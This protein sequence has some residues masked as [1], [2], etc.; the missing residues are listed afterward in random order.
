MV[1]SILMKKGLVVLMA[2]V[3]AILWV[4]PFLFL[5][6]SRGRHQ[7]WPPPPHTIPAMK[8]PIMLPVISILATKGLDG[9]CHNSNKGHYVGAFVSISKFKQGPAPKLACPPYHPSDEGS[10]HGDSCFHPCDK[11][12]DHAGCCHNSNNGH[13]W[14][15]PFPTGAGTKIGQPP[16]PIP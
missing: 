5:N 2:I 10:D 4:L 15:L 9:C 11:G 8:G 7:N 3:M 16:S 12:V 1:V 14:V 13:P 6:S